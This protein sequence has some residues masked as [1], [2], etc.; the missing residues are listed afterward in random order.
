MELS[1]VK[2][3][4]RIMIAQQR[5][6][7]D[8]SIFA[9][10]LV[11]VI[12]SCYFFPFGFTF[13][14]E[15]L[16]TK[17]ILAILGIP[18]LFMKCISMKELRLSKELL[19][20][21]MFAVLFSLFGY[22]SVD[23][24]HSTDYS[25]ANYWISF[26][27]WFL[28]AYCTCVVIRYMHGYLNF[29]LVFN[30]LI[31][32]CVAQCFLALAIDN[33][34]SFKILIDTYISQSTVA[35]VEF[36][37]DADRLYGIGAAVDVAGTRFSIILIGLSAILT[38]T[39]NRDRESSVTT[40]IYWAAFIVISIVGN[41]MSRT[42]TIGMTLGLLYMVSY[43]G[44]FSTNITIGK[45]GMWRTITIVTMILVAIAVYFYNTHDLI[46]EQLR[47]GFE[48]F[49]NWVEK[50]EWTTDSTERLNSVMWIW[51]APDDYKTWIIGKA[52]FSNW[53]DIG[54]DIGYCRFIFYNGLLGLITFSLF[55]IYNA[56]A[57]A[58][59]FPI[60]KLFFVMLLALS[61]IIW[62]KVATDLFIIYALLYCLDDE[63]EKI[64]S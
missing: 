18:L 57:C 9:Y 34:I 61:F 37:N 54:T 30:Y 44:L 21:I 24:N 6:K 7:G 53:H 38:Q 27:T 25:Y 10:V 58:Q 28:G 13:L 1:I 60:Y 36:L 45:L 16:N 56:W 39:T 47:F 43:S 35:E 19:I 29:R 55:F 64:T 23:I 11:G 5:A 48:G 52:L 15:A 14:P 26:S 17:I 20:T 46:R 32:V 22:I 62:L 2:Q 41:M 50:G 33:I 8:I 31:A 49:F 63:H 42:T 12:V 3:D 40:M 51:P 59:K 4:R